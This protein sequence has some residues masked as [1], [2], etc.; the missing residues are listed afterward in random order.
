VIDPLLG[1]PLGTVSAGGFVGVIIMLIL[2]GRLVPRQSL[3]DM[4]EDRD[5][6]RT[7][8]ED[9]QKTAM[10]LGMSMEKLLAYAETTS[11]A[12]TEIQEMTTE[13]RAR[14]AREQAGEAG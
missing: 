11:H 10:Q 9:W 6:W 3:V 14:A 5:K 8:A 12:L 2:V 1:I 7:T 4:R 13:A